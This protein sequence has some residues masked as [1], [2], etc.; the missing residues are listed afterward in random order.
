MFKKVVSQLKNTI[1]R[2][3]KARYFF[4]KNNNNNN[5]IIKIKIYNKV[6]KKLNKKIKVK[7]KI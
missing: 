3:N 5:R 6:T 7:R 4:G 1:L 2:K